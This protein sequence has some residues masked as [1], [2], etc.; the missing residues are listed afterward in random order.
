[1]KKN[2]LNKIL[3]NLSIIVILLN[4]MF[5]YIVMAE[6]VTENI[7]DINVVQG[8]SNTIYMELK[9]KLVE[10]L[11][12]KLED[13]YQYTGTIEDLA[14][15]CGIDLND[16]TPRGITSAEGK[17]IKIDNDTTVNIGFNLKISNGKDNQYK[18]D[19]NPDGT[20][21]QI[22]MVD[23]KSVKNTGADNT[24]TK[25]EEQRKALSTKFLNEVVID[26]R[27]NTY[28]GDTNWDAGGVILKPL[29]FMV[30]CVAD[31]VLGAL[32]K[33]MYSDVTD[34]NKLTSY[35]KR[36]YIDKYRVV[37]SRNIDTMFALATNRKIVFLGLNKTMSSV[38]YPH[39]HYSPEEIFAGK[40]SL[41][42]I[43]FISGTNQAEGLGVVRKTIASCY[44]ALRLIA[45][46]GFLSVLIFTGIKIL[47]SSIA[48]DKAK[49]KEWIIDWIIGFALLYTM[50]YIMAFMLTLISNINDKLNSVMPILTVAAGNGYGSF[51]TNLIGL[52]RF[53]TQ[54]DTLSAKIGYEIMYIML[55]V[56]TFKFTFVYIKRV[57]YTAFLTLI[58]PIVAFTYPIDKLIDGKAQGFSMWFKEY[59]FNA[60]LQPMHYLLYYIMVSSSMEIAVKNPLYAIAVLAFMTEA[61]KMFKKIFGFDKAKGGMVGSLG[62]V[63]ALAAVKGIQKFVGK[64]KNGNSG[65]AYVSYPGAVN[66][67]YR[68]A[69][70]TTSND[71]N[72]ADEDN[73]DNPNQRRVIRTDGDRQPDNR[74]YNIGPTGRPRLN[75]PVKTR[76]QKRQEE[77]RKP[78][79]RLVNNTKKVANK[80]LDND[81]GRA[82]TNAF[83]SKV[84]RGSRA[85]ARK[86]VRP[87]WDTQKSGKWNGKRLI[88]NVAKG[89]LGT[90]VGITAAS[91]QAG[92]SLTDGKYSPIE[93]L[94]SFGAGFAL[95]GNR[96][97]S[98]VK[99]FEEGSYEG[100]NQNEKMEIYKENFRNRDDVIKFC[101]ENFGNDWK[102]YRERIVENYVT[103]GVIDFDDIKQ[104]IK[105]SNKVSKETTDEIARNRNLSEKQKKKIMET[106][107][108][109][110][111]AVGIT[112]LTQKKKRKR[113]KISLITYKKDK[114]NQYLDAITDGM[115]ENQ[116]NEVRK[117][118]TTISAA[119]RYFDRMT[120]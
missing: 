92:I 70:L 21:V 113:E 99:A 1:M 80:A 13:K 53:C 60:L 29:F 24:A 62:T 56:Y 2:I 71:D 69:E 103:R 111:D 74:Q 67:D 54:Y 86:I 5:T 104:C 115:D 112:I 18:N 48:K 78:I 28:S 117:R 73:D 9:N 63:S 27:G 108:D 83:N 25:N 33:F 114:E 45:T 64:G 52:V 38:E 116:A 49:Y 6:S 110:Q 19:S 40:I 50:H 96:V 101:K 4:W 79:H 95:A 20:Y 23:I 59:M 98:F 93:G 31:S 37:D 10:E 81:F 66:K 105:Y 42:N 106:Q 36:N 119:I 22:S 30:N 77:N 39:I 46:I 102:E 58:A 61:E 85:V 51:S 8:Y 91:V 17:S 11:R 44:K 76:A 47:L 89:T 3:I 107:Q 55:V 12:Q 65:E 118:E 7:D 94:T 41:L 16:N 82:A 109:E 90:F 72:E 100:L 68:T 26:S 88:R 14:E 35:V 57:I 84:G 32:Q 97:D 75:K 120:S 87:V 15:I 43:D 34:Q